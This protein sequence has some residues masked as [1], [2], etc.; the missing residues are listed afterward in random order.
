MNNISAITTDKQILVSERDLNRL[1]NFQE[2]FEQIFAELGTLFSVI[3]E[4]TDKFTPEKRLAGIGQTLCMDWTESCQVEREVVARLI[5]TL[6]AA[7]NKA[8]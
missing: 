4:K 7:H 6:E 3:S 8:A 2:C 5:E 1:V